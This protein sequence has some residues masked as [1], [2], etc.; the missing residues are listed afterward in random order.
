MQFD[1]GSGALQVDYVEVLDG[2]LV[3][4]SAQG[5]LLEFREGGYF[6]SNHNRA[7]DG[8]FPAPGQPLFKDLAGPGFVV[9][10]GSLSRDIGSEISTSDVSTMT[11]AVADT[12]RVNLKKRISV[13]VLNLLSGSLVVHD[14]SGEDSTLTITETINVGNSGNFL[15]PADVA[16][17]GQIGRRETSVSFIGNE[18]RNA[19]MFLPAASDLESALEMNHERNVTI[20]SNCTSGSLTVTLAEGYTPIAGDL[21][22]SRTRAGAINYAAGALDLAGNNL[23]LLDPV[24]R[25]AFGNAT[26]QN[27][28]EVTIGSGAL[29]CDSVRD[30]PCTATSEKSRMDEDPDKFGPALSSVPLVSSPFSTVVEHKM[31]GHQNP[32]YVQQTARAAATNGILV[33]GE[34]KGRTTLIARGSS[35]P[36][37]LP[38]LRVD[39]AEGRLTLGGAVVFI[40]ALE[41]SSGTVEL[42]S[43]LIQLHVVGDFGLDGRGATFNMNSLAG[44]LGFERQLVFVYGDYVQIA[45]LNQCEWS[46]DQR[47]R[48]SHT[49]CAGFTWTARSCLRDFQSWCGCT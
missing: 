41:N 11:V 31:L 13:P 39:R 22:I 6:V 38:S 40:P 18:R 34:P 29:L 2:R 17:A 3:T 37:W 20:Q 45:G 24:E 10:A 30:V 4:G 32:E 44:G 28:Q 33:T 35:A 9:Y 21:T 16:K 48:E 8:L 12:A 49:S 15:F 43:S 27:Y 23:V 25:D 19:D 42:A 36:V 7:S 14:V 5:A 47:F 26:A 46:G 1:E